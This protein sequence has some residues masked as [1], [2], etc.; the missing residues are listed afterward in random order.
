MD[1]R[2]SFTIR[3]EK[4]VRHID[5]NVAHKKQMF[6]S[7]HIKVK[8]THNLGIRNLRHWLCNS[9]PQNKTILL[10]FLNYLHKILRA[11]AKWQH[12]RDIFQRLGNVPVSNRIPNA[13]NTK[14][15]INVT[16]DQ[17]S[18]VLWW[19]SPVYPDKFKDSTLIASFQI[20]FNSFSLIILSPDSI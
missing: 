9:C 2:C 17:L 13:P 1:K 7:T 16:A 20:L 14:L 8:T 18:W 19:F 3:N 11:F 5:P 4:I 10:A 12:C 15:L 6:Y